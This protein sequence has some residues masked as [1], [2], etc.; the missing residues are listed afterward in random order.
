MVESR[1]DELNI[2]NNDSSSAFD[3]EDFISHYFD[4]MQITEKQKKERIEAAREILDAVLL[5][6][7]WCEEAPERVQEENTLRG[8]ENLYK[9][10]IFQYTEPDDY[11]DRYVHH[12]ISTLISVTLDHMGEEYFTSVERAAFNA[13]NE[14]NTVFNHVDL[15]RAKDLGFKY[16]TWIAEIDDRTRKD[17][18][19]MNGWTIPIDEWFIF[20]DCMGQ[21][22]HDYENLTQRQLANCRCCLSFS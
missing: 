6:L 17:H 16:K 5:F 13:V 19:E 1:I 14:S 18:L 12:F 7:I 8:F 3:Y 2:L 22:P 21:F 10:V 20:D 4:T 15:E 11:I 9:E